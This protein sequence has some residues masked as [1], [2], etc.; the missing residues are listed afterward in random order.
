MPRKRHFFSVAACESVISPCLRDGA[1]RYLTPGTVQNTRSRCAWRLRF[2]FWNGVRSCVCTVLTFTP[3]LCVISFGIA[4][5]MSVG[6]PA[7]GRRQ[8]I[9]ARD[10]QALHGR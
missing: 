1:Q 10:R 3:V 7:L 9:E 8:R 2:F 4:P 6:E 5:S